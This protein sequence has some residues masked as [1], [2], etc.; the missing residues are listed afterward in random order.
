LAVSRN[1]RVWDVIDMG[2]NSISANQ[3]LRK[4]SA[5][6]FALTDISNDEWLFV[7]QKTKPRN[8]ILYASVF[9][10]GVGSDARLTTTGGSGKGSVVIKS[11][12]PN[13][14][15]PVGLKRVEA[16]AAGGCSISATKFGFD[17]Y[18]HSTS[19]IVELEIGG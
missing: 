13:N 2:K 14:C 4:T 8:L 1:A 19:Q 6:D 5:E 17:G 9:A 10:I 15:S 16:I 11:E 18:L 7:G 3:A 12:D